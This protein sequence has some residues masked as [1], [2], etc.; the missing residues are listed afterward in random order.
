VIAKVG[1]RGQHPLMPCLP[2]L[3]GYCTPILYFLVARLECIPKARFLGLIQKTHL[4][5]AINARFINAPHRIFC[6]FTCF[7]CASE[8]A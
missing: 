5:S 7:H 4:A 1:Q 2:P 6:Q 8:H 3:I